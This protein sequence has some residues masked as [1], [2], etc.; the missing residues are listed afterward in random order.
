MQLPCQFQDPL[1][2]PVTAVQLTFCCLP[3]SVS[4]GRCIRVLNLVFVGCSWSALGFP[5]PKKCAHQNDPLNQCNLHELKL[6]LKIVRYPG[7]EVDLH[8]LKLRL[9]IV[10]YPGIEVDQ[11]ALNEQARHSIRHQNNLDLKSRLF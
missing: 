2:W 9:R 4:I 7:I 10:R 11:I 8:E 5:F 1:N 3:S 6:R